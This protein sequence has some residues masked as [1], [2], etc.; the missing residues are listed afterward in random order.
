VKT[1]AKR[2]TAPSPKLTGRPA[3]KGM[4]HKDKRGD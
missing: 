3:S 4:V 2:R 1:P